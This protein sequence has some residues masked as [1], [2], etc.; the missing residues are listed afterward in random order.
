[1]Q[2]EALN[3]ASWSSCWGGRRISTE[4]LTCNYELT[5]VRKRTFGKD[6]SRHSTGWR[7]DNKQFSLRM[8]SFLVLSTKLNLA[9]SDY[10]LLKKFTH[11]ESKIIYIYIIQSINI[12]RPRS[13]PGLFLGNLMNVRQTTLHLEWKVDFKARKN[14]PR[15]YFLVS[16]YYDTTKLE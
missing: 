16:S 3:P 13:M 1:M 15:C 5:L 7:S 11:W 10:Q 14:V 2:H 9:Q 8:I 4:W 12:T 6:W